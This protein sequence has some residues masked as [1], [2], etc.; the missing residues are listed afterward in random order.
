M[1]MRNASVLG[2]VLSAAA[3]PLI[4][5]QPELLTQ[6]DDS[7]PWKSKEGTCEGWDQ[8]SLEGVA[9]LWEKTAAGIQ[10]ELRLK[11]HWGRSRFPLVQRYLGRDTLVLL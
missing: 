4:Q 2:L 11:I 9:D 1:M 6:E 5:A 10:L 7:E 8:R 3:S